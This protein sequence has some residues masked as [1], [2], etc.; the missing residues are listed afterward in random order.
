MRPQLTSYW[1]NQT[2]TPTIRRKQKHFW[3]SRKNKIRTSTIIIATRSGNVFLYLLSLLM[4][5]F[6]RRYWSYAQS[7]FYS[8]KNIYKNPFCT[9]VDGLTVRSKSRLQD[10]THIWF[11][12]LVYLFTYGT[13]IYTGN[14]VWIW[15]WHNKLCARIV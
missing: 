4:A 13:E 3:P 2:V 6:E 8:W 9:C 1:G 7:W 15:Y 10:R 11:V 5:W 12:E 14:W